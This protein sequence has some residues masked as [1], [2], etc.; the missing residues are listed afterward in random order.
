MSGKKR[1][2]PGPG[3]TYK[4]HL[5]RVC[6]KEIGVAT[7]CGVEHYS[8]LMVNQ[9]SGKVNRRLSLRRLVCTYCLT[10]GK[11]TFID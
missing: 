11:L 5:C 8:H 7:S 6:E 10:R 2:N 1:Q 4:Q 9:K 3:P